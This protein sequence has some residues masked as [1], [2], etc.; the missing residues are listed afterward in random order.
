MEIFLG[1]RDK[2]GACAALRLLAATPGS[3]IG[4]DARGN[5]SLR[6][7]DQLTRNPS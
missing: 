6:D 7:T 1:K 4:A 3:T 5:S 2:I